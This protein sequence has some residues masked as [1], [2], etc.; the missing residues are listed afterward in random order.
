MYDMQAIYDNVLQHPKIA[1]YEMIGPPP[2]YSLFPHP[3]TEEIGLFD[4]CHPGK[5]HAQSTVWKFTIRENGIS[6]LCYRKAID[7]YVCLE[8]AKSYHRLLRIIEPYRKDGSF[9]E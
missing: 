9:R 6:L 8:I 7:S 1:G 5:K 2:G 4:S 3:T